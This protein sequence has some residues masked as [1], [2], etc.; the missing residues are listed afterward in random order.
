ME[1]TTLIQPSFSSI[2]T[3]L[4]IQANIDLTS[5][6]F[7]YLIFPYAF[8]NFN[9]QPISIV[10]K[11]AGVVIFTYNATVIDRTLEIAMSS[12]IVANT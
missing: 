8:N 4:Y 6:S 2:F 9:N 10:L 7:L 12:T 1:V 3:T 5:G 11:V